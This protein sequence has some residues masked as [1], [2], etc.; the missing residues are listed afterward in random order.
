MIFEKSYDD[1]QLSLMI[2]DYSRNK[3]ISKNCF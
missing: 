1:N 2:I 3:L